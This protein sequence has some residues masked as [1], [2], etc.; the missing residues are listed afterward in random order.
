ARRQLADAAPHDPR[1]EPADLA[2]RLAERRRTHLHLELAHLLGGD[3]RARH[4]APA[5]HL[6][7]PALADVVPDQVPAVL[8]RPPRP[9]EPPRPI[10]PANRSRTTAI[11]S[12][13]T[14]KWKGTVA[15]VATM[16]PS[17]S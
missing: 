3:V 9:P 10:R 1:R 17:A 11:A 12:A 2:Q 16:C 5:I 13:E 4:E 14:P 7:R 15:A 6:H 8:D